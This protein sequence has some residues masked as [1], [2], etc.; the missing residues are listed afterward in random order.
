MGAAVADKVVTMTQGNKLAASFLAGAAIVYVLDHYGTAALL[1]IVG[2]AWLAVAALVVLVSYMAHREPRRPTWRDL[3]R[4]PKGVSKQLKR[5]REE[6]R[7][8]IW[9]KEVT[10]EE[11]TTSSPG[12]TPRKI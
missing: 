9:I 11:T 12:Q 3:V 1:D 5:E 2:Y 7:R 10:A 4:D 8:Q 6:L